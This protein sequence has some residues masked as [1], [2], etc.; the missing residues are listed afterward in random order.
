MASV[1]GTGSKA[2]SKGKAADP[3]KLPGITVESLREQLRQNRAIFRTQQPIRRELSNQTLEAL[4]TGGVNAR[5]PLVQKAVEQ[6]RSASAG[7]MRQTQQN[8]AQGNLMN[9]PFGQSILAQQGQAARFAESQ[10]GPAFAQ[11][12]IAGAG[13]GGGPQFGSLPG[14]ASVSG[15]NVDLSGLGSFLGNLFRKDPQT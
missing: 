2:Q 1:T 9:T 12:L 13:G 11:Q 3:T 4:R 8:L 15:G 10:I 7:Q 6:A 5:L 14:G